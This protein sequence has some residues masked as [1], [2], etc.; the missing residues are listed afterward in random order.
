MYRI[1]DSRILR[2]G[3]VAA[4]VVGLM[5]S[6]GTAVAYEEWEKG[7]VPGREF[8][9]FQSEAVIDVGCWGTDRFF[10]PLPKPITLGGTFR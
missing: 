5:V 3:L 2:L 8:D 1:K 7:N 6:T 10:R 9:D 4:L